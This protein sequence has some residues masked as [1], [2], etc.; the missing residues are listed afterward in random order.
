MRCEPKT[1]KDMGFLGF[2]F[3]FLVLYDGILKGRE[4]IVLWLESTGREWGASYDE[5]KLK[6]NPNEAC[7]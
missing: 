2:F 5:V 3:F 1:E 4:E 7:M 6:K